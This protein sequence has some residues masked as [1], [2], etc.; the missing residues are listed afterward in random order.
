MFHWQSRSDAKGMHSVLIL[1]MY[2]GVGSQQTKL[3]CNTNRSSCCHRTGCFQLK[4]QGRTDVKGIHS[5]VGIGCCAAVL[6]YSTLLCSSVELHNRCSCRRKQGGLELKWQSSTVA[7][8]IHS[9]MG[10]VVPGCCC[11]PYQKR[12]A[13]HTAVQYPNTIA[14]QHCSW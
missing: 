2:K 6:N 5:V 4:W 10:I 8:G 14:L 13:V 7:K 1:L 9:D 12:S 3:H 11:C